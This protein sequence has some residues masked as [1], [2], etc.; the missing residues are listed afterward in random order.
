MIKNVRASSQPNHGVRFSSR[1]IKIEDQPDGTSL[2]NCTHQLVSP[3]CQ[4]LPTSAA[5]LRFVLKIWR[6]CTGFSKIWQRLSRCR[7]SPCLCCC[8]SAPHSRRLDKWLHPVE[9]NVG[10]NFR[11]N[12]RFSFEA[13]GQ[14]RSFLHCH[15]CSLS[16]SIIAVIP[17]HGLAGSKCIHRLSNCRRDQ[18]L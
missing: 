16:S 7:K 14:G 6:I 1:T 11:G 9:R 3:V 10:C 4:R 17:R 15:C 18:R 13:L 2:Y 12:R 8:Q 5:P